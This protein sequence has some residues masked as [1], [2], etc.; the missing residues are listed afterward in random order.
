MPIDTVLGTG[1]GVAVDADQLSHSDRDRLGYA[2]EQGQGVWL[3]VVPTQIPHEVNPDQVAERALR[4]LRRFGL[5]PSLTSRVVL[6][7]ACGFAG[8]TTAAALQATRALARATEQVAE[9]LSADS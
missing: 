5:D 6:T 8:W 1:A 9:R 2:V 7:P 4:V 3:G